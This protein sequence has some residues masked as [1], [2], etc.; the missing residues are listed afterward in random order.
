MGLTPRPPPSPLTFCAPTYTHTHPCHCA[1]LPGIGIYKGQ[2][3]APHQSPSRQEVGPR[4]LFFLGEIFTGS[5][6][7]IPSRQVQAGRRCCHQ[8][9]KIIKRG[10]GDQTDCGWGQPALNSSPTG[11]RKGQVIGRK[12]KQEL[13]GTMRCASTPP[14]KPLLSCPHSG[15]WPVELGALSCQATMGFSAVVCLL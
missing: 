12:V 15:Q 8:Q 10:F 5:Q 13:A 3:K 14:G 4:L 1:S 2:A 9:N 11:L 7:C 6:Q